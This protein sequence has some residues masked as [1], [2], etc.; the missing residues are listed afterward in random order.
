MQKQHHR[1]GFAAHFQRSAPASGTAAARALPF[2]YAAQFPITGKPGTVQQD[3]I[4]I[5][6]EATFVALGISYGFEQERG[7]SLGAFLNITDPP[8]LTSPLLP[9]DLTLG[10]IPLDV[11]AEGFRVNPR[12]LPIVFETSSDN[13]DGVVLTGNFSSNQITADFLNQTPVFERVQAPADIE[14]LFSM[15]DTATGREFQ[16][17]PTHNIASLGSSDGR[18][19][20]R[21]FSRPVHLLPRSTIRIQIVERSDDVQGTLFIVLFGY[22]LGGSSACSEAEQTSMAGMDASSLLPYGKVIPFDY[23]TRFQLK[24]RESNR[25]DDEIAINTEGGYYATSIGYGLQVEDANVQFNVSGTGTV[26]LRT[27]KLSNFP[28]SALTDGFRIKPGFMRLAVGGA[29]TLNQTLPVDLVHSIFETLNRVEDVSFRYSIFD[30]GTGRELQNEP[31]QNIAGLGIANGD[32]PF[33]KLARPLHL[34]PRSTL[35]VS[36]EERFGRG[37][38]FIVLQGYKLLSGPTAAG[39]QR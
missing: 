31:I 7:R 4:N 16:D 32:R 39:G 38:L 34:E 36:I 19:P 23:V 11:L 20:F 33:K 13:G 9:G 37:D 8:P 17:Q 22:K 21:M 26:D 14:F 5:S 1:P 18:R 3:V 30:S 6:P 24:G 28:V 25:V 15:V 35:R 29:G 12:Y 27:V 10:H 2:D